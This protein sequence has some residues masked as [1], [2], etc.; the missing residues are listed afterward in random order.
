VAD[1]ILIAPGQTLTV[2]DWDAVLLQHGD[3]LPNAQ[4]QNIGIV[5]PLITG[6]LAAR[7]TLAAHVQQHP[8]YRYTMADGSTVVA[9]GTG[10][11][12]EV[13]ILEY[14]PSAKFAAAQTK[15]AAN[16]PA[17]RTPAQDNEAALNEQ[18][19]R[20]AALPGPN[21]QGA[22]EDE[23]RG[24]DPRYETD[25]ERARRAETTIK[26]QGADARA[27]EDRRRADA[28]KSSR[29]SET[30]GGKA[31]DKVTTVT[32]RPDGGTD[33]EQHYE[34]P[35]KPGVKIPTPLAPPTGLGTPAGSTTT[36]TADGK[37]TKVTDYLQPDGSTK[38]VTDTVSQPPKATETERD[39]TTGRTYEIVR[40]P[41]NTVKERREVPTTGPGADAASQY[42][43]PE[44]KL[45]YGNI[46][47]ELMNISRDIYSRVGVGP[48]KITTEEANRLFKPIYE[49]AQMRVS[50]L[51]SIVE[52]QK[53]VW[54]SQVST[55][56]QRL[57]EATRMAGQAMGMANQAQLMAPGTGAV[58]GQMVWDMLHAQRDFAGSMGGLKDPTLPGYLG[59]AMGMGPDSPG[60]VPP[61]GQP[62]AVPGSSVQ[63]AA[64]GPNAL[65]LGA[66]GA[67]AA[68]GGPPVT[69][70]AP[71]PALAAAEAARQQAQAQAVAPPP[72][73]L[74]SPAIGPAG[75]D[76]GFR[77]GPPGGGE[78]QDPGFRVGPPG[79]GE[80][81]DPGFRQ[82]PPA[83]QG[84][85]NPAAGGGITINIGGAS[86][87][88]PDPTSLASA[89]YLN[90][91]QNPQRPGLGDVQRQL[92]GSLLSGPGA[93]DE[94]VLEH[95]WSKKTGQSLLNRGRM[96]AG[97]FG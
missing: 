82:G 76:P 5:D 93:F 58:A 35:A 41:D 64:G 88:Q 39:P 37:T 29:V 21:A 94:D 69:G 48:G 2:P 46:S 14:K 78:A 11:G 65:G 77:V 45:A 92:A 56:N 17:N 59:A 96:G 16:D 20:N 89:D 3:L 51:N 38:Q 67:V 47:Q 84:Y 4:P 61:P 55:A 23:R 32:T 50:E 62:A 1:P 27:A 49:Q 97:A 36:Q 87:A 34:D 53:S 33:T 15:A 42:T 75:S 22:T 86:Q 6:K 13:E 7:P 10:N 81:Q 83:P 30:I 60:A 63:A 90:P 26:Q 52:T 57:S 66:V 70:A 12:D 72:V 8:A 31:Y 28:G 43:Y 24:Q 25:E 74:P 80:A 19:R 73:P 85:L 9:M 18:R 54:Q 91:A 40:N 95:V 79:G 44:I 68:P 71:D